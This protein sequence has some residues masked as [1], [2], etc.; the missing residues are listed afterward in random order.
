MK[1]CLA[2]IIL[3]S[4]L[5]LGAC[6]DTSVTV[7]F[8]GTCLM[9]FFRCFSPQGAYSCSYNKT[10]RELK[11]TWSNGAYLLRRI[12]QTDLQVISPQGTNCFSITQNTASNLTT[13]WTSTETFD[14]KDLGQE[15]E[16]TC[17]DQTKQKITKPYNPAALDL[18]FDDGNSNNLLCPGLSCKS[19]NDCPPTSIYRCEPVAGQEVGNCVNR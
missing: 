8:V 1:K 12:P 10:T 5:L 14:L 9:P 17:S 15:L 3:T 13:Y 11:V 4:Q 7:P 16:I 19:D 2:A 6:S 18:Y